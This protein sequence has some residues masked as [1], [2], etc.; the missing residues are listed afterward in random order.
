M[1]NRWTSFRV[2]DYQRGVD[3]VLTSFFFY[4]RTAA[5]PKHQTAEDEKMLS[6]D[7]TETKIYILVKIN[8]QLVVAARETFI[9][10]NKNVYRKAVIHTVN[11]IYDGTN[12]WCGS[13]QLTVIIFR[14]DRLEKEKEKKRHQS[15]SL[16]MILVNTP[17]FQTASDKVIKQHVVCFTEPQVSRFCLPPCSC[18]LPESSPHHLFE[19]S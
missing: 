7:V 14:E 3:K 1:T 2:S 16:L 5:K 6:Y 9:S 17:V 8:V 19:S 11:I 13:A 15:G 18:N 12:K 4:A 10:L